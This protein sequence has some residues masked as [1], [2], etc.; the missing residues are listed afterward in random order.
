MVFYYDHNGK[1]VAFRNTDGAVYFYVYNL[2]GDVV[3]LLDSSRNVVGEYVYGPYGYLENSS[4]LTTVAKANPFRYR[5]YYYDTENGYYYLNARYYYPVFGRFISADG[6]EVIV[7]EPNSCNLYAYCYNNPI[8]NEDS[9][10]ASPYGILGIADYYVIH[11]M[12]QKYCCKDGWYIEVYV[13]NGNKRGFLDIFDPD[14]NE[15]YE[16]KSSLYVKHNYGLVIEQ[17]ERYKKS[18]LAG[19]TNMKR[20]FAMD[21]PITPGTGSFKNSFSYGI[22]DVFYESSEA[23]QGLITYE[24]KPNVQKCAALATVIVVMGLTILIPES[25]PITWPITGP[26]VVPLFS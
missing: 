17:M 3:Q 10:G 20:G 6:F 12:V 26:V 5:G 16:V 15:F 8:C 1:R 19:R 13:K 14:N 24:I 4:S 11:K 18:S 25:A 22:Y 21:K 7:S 2:Q 9:I 23:K